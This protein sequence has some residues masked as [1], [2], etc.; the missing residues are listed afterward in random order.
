MLKHAKADQIEMNIERNN[1]DLHISI[2]DNGIGFDPEKLKES[3]GLGW[4]NIFS[5]ISMLDG[6]IKLESQPQKGTSVYINLKLK[7]G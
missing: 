6:N 4:K 2:K 3:K 7:N 1:S 5:R